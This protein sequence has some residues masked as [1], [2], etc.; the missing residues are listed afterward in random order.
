MIFDS[1]EDLFIYARRPRYAYEKSC[2]V[3]AENLPPR[4]WA[5]GQMHEK[6]NGDWEVVKKNDWKVPR[7]L[8][9]R[10]R[11]FKAKVDFFVRKGKEFIYTLKEGSIVTDIETIAKG[12]GIRKVHFLIKKYRKP[13][14]NKTAPGDW[15][16]SK[17]KG[18]VQDKYGNEAKAELHWYECKG[19]GKVDFKV[20]KWEK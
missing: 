15:I 12:H 10:A 18:I 5:D 8:G 13:N 6:V 14:G 2:T 16:K 11:K 20:K 4:K 1:L 17:G 9:A 3:D 19:L 7:S